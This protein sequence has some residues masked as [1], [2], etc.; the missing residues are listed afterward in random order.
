MAWVGARAFDAVEVSSFQALVAP[1]LVDSYELQDRVFAG[2]DP[3]ADAAGPR[4]DRPHR[5]RRPA[6]TDAQ[7]DGQS[8]TPSSRPPTST[9]PSSARPAAGWPSR[10]CVPSGRLRRECR[11]GHR[12]TG[13]TGSTTKPPRSTATS[14]SR[15]VRFVTANVNLW[16]RPLVF[17]INADRFAALTDEQQEILTAAAAAAIEPASAATRREESERGSGPV[18][19]RHDCRRGQRLRSRTHWRVRWSRSSPSS[20][21]IPRRR[22]SSTR[23]AP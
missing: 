21:P 2:G 17:V 3:A 19:D 22:R 1:F 15:E 13:W 12:S 10:R 20:R 23:S 9:A 5:H 18:F 16:P 7:A 8:R 6:R 4:R 11:R 14:T